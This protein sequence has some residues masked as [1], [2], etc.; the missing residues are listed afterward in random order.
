[1]GE[2]RVTHRALVEKTARK[3]PLGKCRRRWEDNVKMDVIKIG[4]KGLNWIDVAQ[5]WQRGKLF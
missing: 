1:M 3:R 5:N 4:W 2:R